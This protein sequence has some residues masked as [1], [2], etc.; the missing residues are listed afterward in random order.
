MH[1][2]GPQITNTTQQRKDCLIPYDSI[3]YW[4]L[5]SCC[6]KAWFPCRVSKEMMVWRLFLCGSQPL[7]AYCDPLPRWWYLKSRKYSRGYDPNV[8]MA[9]N[10]IKSL[11]LLTF[12]SRFQF[13]HWQHHLK[14]AFT[15]NQSLTN[16]LLK[17]GNLIAKLWLVYEI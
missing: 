14:H 17:I 9:Y 7:I 1:V 15:Q 3:S 13:W 4:H 2:V 10:F 11:S 6:R 5:K 16:V 12:G 8:C